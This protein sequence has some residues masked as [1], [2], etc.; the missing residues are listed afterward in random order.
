MTP[1]VRLPDRLPSLTGLRFFGAVAVIVFH[2]I[3]LPPITVFQDEK[4]NGILAFLVGKI[5]FVSVTFFFILSG[6]VLTWSAR[7][8]DTPRMFYRRR[9]FRIF[10]NH[11]V[12]WAACLILLGGAPVW[13]ALLNLLL[14][15]SWVPRLEVASSVNIVTWSL[16][17][18]VFFYALFPFLLRGVQ[19]ITRGRL[20]Y[21]AV[22]ALLT[23]IAV[24]FIAVLVMPD[25]PVI[26][27]INVPTYE[28]WFSYN[29][30]VARLGEFVLGMVL[31]RIVRERLWFGLPLWAAL[32]ILGVTY[33][34]MLPVPIPYGIVAV[35]VAPSALLVLAA[36]TTEIRGTN[37]FFGSRLSLWLGNISYALFMSHAIVLY[38]GRPFFLGDQKFSTPVALG[39]V[40]LAVALSILL[41]WLLYITVERP[42]ARRWSH[43]APARTR[44]VPAV[45]SSGA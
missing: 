42:I 10:P 16:S 20:W 39:L 24:P 33:L 18:E 7:A 26:P 27:V 37:R 38:W 4:V 14:V 9:F 40:A 36:A 31:A 29:F 41:A 8:D 11:V 5:G 3:V 17:C 45:T 44:S 43:P 15:Q 21:W 19:R 13:I 23:T 1:P 32:A 35:E 6:F 34:A 30:P 22:G 12:T 2:A 28:Y 25:Q